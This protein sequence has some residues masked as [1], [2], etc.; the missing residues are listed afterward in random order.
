MVSLNYNIIKYEK[1]YWH[2]NKDITERKVFKR[3]DK[4]LL[5][6]HFKFDHNKLFPNKEIT[7]LGFLVGID[8]KKYGVY[9]DFLQSYNDLEHLNL[10]GSS[11]LLDDLL[12]NI[13]Q[14]LKV[15]HFSNGVFLY[16]GVKWPKV[17]YDYSPIFEGD[18]ESLKL[19][20][21]SPNAIFEISKPQVHTKQLILG[22]HENKQFDLSKFPNL[23]HYVEVMPYSSTKDYSPIQY[24]KHLHLGGRTLDLSFLQD[25]T[26]LETLVIDNFK[27]LTDLSFLKGLENLEY[28]C[29]AQ[30]THLENLKGI[31]HCPKLKYLFLHVGKKFDIK[32]LDKIA[33][34]S[35]IQKIG[36]QR[37]ST[38][39]YTKL[40]KMMIKLFGEKASPYRLS[41]LIKPNG[42][43]VISDHARGYTD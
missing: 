37:I 19:Q 34:M 24:I 23:D 28:L 35:N 25:F 5:T 17:N 31:Q 26:D 21:D 30:A 10:V 4:H 18:Y 8:V 32:E 12:P 22:T 43:Y 13:P 33:R 29:V 39:G 7:H 14:K 6:S 36:F 9:F 40:Q 3:L 15:F 20:A 11:I 27:N 1:F 42:K 41:P 38:S 16:S 2:P